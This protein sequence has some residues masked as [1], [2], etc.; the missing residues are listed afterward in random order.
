[1]RQELYVA[2]V[3]T[4]FDASVGR[5]ASTKCMKLHVWYAST[6][7]YTRTNI[8]VFLRGNDVPLHTHL[9]VDC[10]RLFCGV[11]WTGTGSTSLQD[12]CTA[13]GSGPLGQPSL[14]LAMLACSSL[15]LTLMRLWRGVRQPDAQQ[16][17]CSA[18]PQS[19]LSAPTAAGGR[20]E[21]GG[22]SSSGYDSL[23]QDGKTQVHADQDGWCSS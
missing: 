3:P 2:P 15:S 22:G 4:H 18:T 14:V 9:G 21:G 8:R 11:F 16:P 23:P 10:C 12:M 6:H 7:I 20:P 19:G 5:C 17:A 1:L 13:L